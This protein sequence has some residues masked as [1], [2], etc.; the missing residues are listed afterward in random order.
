[1]NE[2]ADEQAIREK[3]NQLLAEIRADLLKRQL[4]NSENYD[5]AVLT[6]S[7][8]FLGISFAFLKDFVP[9]DRAGCLFLLIVSWVALTVSVVSTIVSFCLSQ[10]AIDV[11][12][13]KAEDYYLRDDQTALKKTRIAKAVDV[14]NIASGALFVVGVLLTTAFVIINLK[15]GMKM[16]D[17][18]MGQTKTL[19][20]GAPIPQMQEIPS[21]RGAPIPN[22]QQVPQS[23]PPQNQPP[24]Q[25]VPTAPPARS[26]PSGDSKKGN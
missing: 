22:I 23:Q 24:A 14:V 20:E 10:R 11:Q 7:T 12:L 25:S 13:G 2:A 26:G 19:R 16:G 9:T 4:S 3:K 21:K 6:L 1:M 17:D 15:G 5:R 18:K 8:A